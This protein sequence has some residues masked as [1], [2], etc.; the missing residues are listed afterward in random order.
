MIIN[1]LVGKKVKRAVGYV[2]VSTAEQADEG[3]SIAA[4]GEL[5]RQECS[6]YGSELQFVRLYADEGISGKSI[7]RRPQMQQL[8]ADVQA[9][10]I[11]AVI[12]WNI[13]RIARN[14]ANLLEIVD[15]FESNDVSFISINE[16]MDTQ[17][18]AGRLMLQIMASMGEYERNNIAENVYMGSRRRAVEGWNNSGLVLGYDNVTDKDGN[19]TLQINSD[20]ASIIKHI[21]DLAALGKGLRAIANELNKMG[22]CTKRGNSFSTAAVKVI[23]TNPLYVGKVRYGRYRHWEKKRRHGKQSDYILVD[24][25]HPAIIDPQQWS[26]VVSLMKQRHKLPAWTRQGSNVLTGLLRCP[27]CGGPMAASNTTNSLAD[28]TRKRIRYYSCAN[29]RNKGTAVCHANSIRAEVAEQLVQEKLLRT[30]SLPKI[31]QQV[32]EQMKNSRLKR[33]KNLKRQQQNNQADQEKLEKNIQEYEQLMVDNHE[34]RAAVRPRLES[35]S[36]LL[37]QL[38]V[39]KQQVDKQLAQVDQVPKPKTINDLLLLVVKLVKKADKGVLKQLYQAFIQ[40]ITFD[41]KK[42]LVWITVAFDDDVI[43]Q[44]KTQGK[45]VELDKGSTAFSVLAFMFTF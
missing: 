43:Q 15:I 23:L 20:E 16:K 26:R 22:V 11:D 38:R 25:H 8:L 13:S 39:D 9:G 6:R 27:E 12:C 24:G 40:K 5:I 7:K 17:T 41:R 30:L 10:E 2:R 21:F 1:E 37:D 29:F 42:K 34:L 4:Q 28:G 3:F 18:P 32:I 36:N 45:A 44:L 14:V 35:L 31:G 19:H 33:C